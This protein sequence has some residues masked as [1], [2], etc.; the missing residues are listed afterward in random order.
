MALIIKDR[1]KETSTTSGTGPLTLNG[2]ATGY[3]SFSVIGSGNSTYYCIADQNG[4]NWEV[5]IGIWNNNGTLSRNTIISNSAGTTTPIS[6]TS[7]VKDVFCT[8]PSEKALMGTTSALDSTGTG[9]VV[10]SNTPTINSPVLNSPNMIGNISANV[11]LRSGTINQLLGYAGGSS[12]IGYAT[13]VDTLVKFTGVAGQAEVYGKYTN[14][15]TLN[16]TITDA[17]A[18]TII[19]CRYITYLNIIFDPTIG[20][21]ISN[22]NIKFPLST[23]I[24]KFTVAFNINAGYDLAQ[25]GPKFT[26][27]PSYQPE[28]II[29]GF[30]TYT[31]I[32]NDNA[33][34]PAFILSG[35]SGASV[36][37]YNL[38]INFMLSNMLG[39]GWTRL[40][41]PGEALFKSAVPLGYIGEVVV[42]SQ[43]TTGSMTS[44]TVYNSGSIS[45]TPGTWLLWGGVTF[46]T[47]STLNAAALEA[48]TNLASTSID[49]SSF[50]PD[51]G[52]VKIEQPTA[53][54]QSIK[55]AISPIVVVT[56]S[57][58]T[59]YSN[60]KFTAGTGNTGTVSAI[61][62][63]RAVRIA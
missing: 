36:Y 16:Y 40:P 61:V 32:C 34:S 1:V 51:V 5:G 59:K 12:E 4:P 25:N 20:N 11:N 26:I 58:V 2:A 27:T 29:N 50:N 63:Q 30:N 33:S 3:Q 10:L 24:S 9:S 43:L 53:T 44:G 45:L 42:G 23:N 46:T 31:P 57:S 15:T 38:E 52:A 48:A 13:D 54:A 21:T 39:N 22:L 37:P 62:Y 19:D 8:Y 18:S 6:F 56:A 41:I 49:P 28:D 14:G 47:T 60:A 35:A 7:V 55:A 17:N